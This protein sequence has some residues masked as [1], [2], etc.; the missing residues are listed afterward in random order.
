MM[1]ALVSRLPGEL[2]VLV[3]LLAI[4][5]ELER[6]NHFVVTRQTF[7]TDQHKIWRLYSELTKQIFRPIERLVTRVAQTAR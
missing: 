5:R 3:R 1:D 4:L 7:L 6:L 2:D